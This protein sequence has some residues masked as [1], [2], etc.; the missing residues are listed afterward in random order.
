[1]L[2]F[3][4]PDSDYALLPLIAVATITTVPLWFLFL[5]KKII[6]KKKKE[7]SSFFEYAAENEKNDLNLSKNLINQVKI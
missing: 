2:N 3:E 5:F 6:S 4:S 7:S 1:M